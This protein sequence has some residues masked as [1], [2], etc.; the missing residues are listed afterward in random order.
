MKRVHIGPLPPP[1][2]GISVYLYRLSK[3]EKDSIFIDTKKFVSPLNFNLWLIK[4]IFSLKKKNFIYHS[5][6]LNARLKFYFL[7]CVSIHKFSLVIHG[8]SLIDQYNKSK[9]IIRHLIK[10]M[11]K[12]A[13]FIQVV[14]P[15]IKGFIQ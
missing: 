1:L 2:G 14:D 5:P 3:L 6:S 7:S 13:Y 9:N 15:K 4:Q 12:S 10:L 11:L 8:N